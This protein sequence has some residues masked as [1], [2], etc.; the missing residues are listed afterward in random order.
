MIDKKEI[1]YLYIATTRALKCALRAQSDL[2]D[3]QEY[4]EEHLADNEEIKKLL[5]ELEKDMRKR[6]H[7]ESVIL[8]IIHYHHYDEE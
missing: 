8:G 5:S 1:D 7:A 6:E 4:V 2:E 3:I